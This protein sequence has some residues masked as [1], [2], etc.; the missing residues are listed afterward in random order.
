MQKSGEILAELLDDD[1]EVSG[2]ETTIEI[3]FAIMKIKH[4]IKR[5]KRRQ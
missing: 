2:E 4:T 1:L 5:N 3:N